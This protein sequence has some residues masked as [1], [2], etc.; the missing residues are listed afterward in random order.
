MK[1]EATTKLNICFLEKSRNACDQLREPCDFV[2][3]LDDWHGAGAV[4]ISSGN[5]NV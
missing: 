3:W 1:I 4:S 2:L 5:G